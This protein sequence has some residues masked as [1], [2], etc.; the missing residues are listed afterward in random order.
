MVNDYFYTDSLF[1]NSMSDIGLVFDFKQLEPIDGGITVLTCYNGNDTTVLFEQMSF[2]DIPCINIMDHMSCVDLDIPFTDDMNVLYT[3][4]IN[5]ALERVNTEYVVYIQNPN[6]LVKS[7]KGLSDEYGWNGCCIMFS[8]KKKD[9]GLLS[10]TVK[11][12]G[13]MIDT[14]VTFGKT[15]Y[16]KEFF[17]K[18]SVLRDKLSICHHMEK[19][20]Q[21]L[22]NTGMNGFVRRFVD[23]IRLSPIGIP[24]TLYGVG[25]L[26]TNSI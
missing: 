7:F 5:N 14:S 24:Q 1:L 23:D 2:N 8:V 20:E 12:D 17:A 3:N 19:Y 15:V 21:G 6:T 26:N 16:M 11:E 9:V 13:Y 25:L 18:L 10:T 22:V 4:F